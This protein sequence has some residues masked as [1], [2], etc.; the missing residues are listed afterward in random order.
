MK[1]INVVN[2][3]KYQP[4]YRD[5]NLIWIKVYCSLVNGSYEFEMLHEI[6][7]WRFIALCLMQTQTK[8]PVPSVVSYLKQKGWNFQHRNLTLTLKS[9]QSA[10][11]VD[12]VDVTEPSTSV[13]QDVTECDVDKSRVDKNRLD[14][15]RK[16]QGFL[17]L[18]SRYPNKDG[19]RSAET[20]Y[21]SSVIT[22]DDLILINKALD[23]YLI[24]D[25]VARGF[26]KNGSTWF[27]NWHDW[28][29]DPTTDEATRKARAIGEK[30]GLKPNQNKK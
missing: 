3:E 1:A 24:S 7:K 4:G 30:Y 25:K 27:N 6:D 20:K 8:K 14:K 26:V 5:R 23:N 9:L 10:Q 2:L 11:L 18:W 29:E 19:R 12:I 21:E 22:E 28:I 15:K 16:E 13:L 17:D